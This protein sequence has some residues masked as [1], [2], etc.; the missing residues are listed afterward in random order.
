[1]SFTTQIILKYTLLNFACFKKTIFRYLVHHICT[2][3]FW[4]LYRKKHFQSIW[5]THKYLSRNLIWGICLTYSSCF[6]FNGYK[7]IKSIVPYFSLL[8]NQKWDEI[9][10]NHSRGLKCKTFQD[11]FVYPVQNAQRDG[12][13]WRRSSKYFILCMPNK[14]IE[15]NIL[16][17]SLSTSIFYPPSNFSIKQHQSIHGGWSI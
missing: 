13:C 2:Y 10:L 3:L 7:L 5:C 6:E 17:K 9:E 14:F 15:W 16:E 11:S 8:W 4:Y 1:M 12:L